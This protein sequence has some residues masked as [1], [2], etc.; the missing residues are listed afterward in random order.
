MA[1]SAVL[2][3]D[4]VSNPELW[5]GWEELKYRAVRCEF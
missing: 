5:G 4:L 2:G 3:W 1:A